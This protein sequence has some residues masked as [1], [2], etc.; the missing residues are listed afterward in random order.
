MIEQNAKPKWKRQGIR[1]Y[2]IGAVCMCVAAALMHAQVSDHLSPPPSR[3][4]WV[5]DRFATGWPFLSTTVDRSSS[6]CGPFGGR[7][8][9][10]R[11]SFLL[12]LLICTTLLSLTVARLVSWFSPRG[13]VRQFTLS[14]MFICVTAVSIVVFLFIW[15]S[16]SQPI[17]VPG[18]YLRHGDYLALATF[19]TYDQLPIW[20]CVFCAV[21]S[22]L[23]MAQRLAVPGANNGRPTP[24]EDAQDGVSVSQD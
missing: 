1:W 14:D 12:N 15:D 11:G 4:G 23:K 16:N 20:F 24:R 7:R 19:P 21:L 10:S 2:I 3:R 22:A 17:G 6:G 13:P 5:G 8:L 18:S 9:V